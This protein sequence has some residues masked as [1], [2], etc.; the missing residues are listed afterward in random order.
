MSPPPFRFLATAGLGLALSLAV[1]GACATPP[2]T[3][4]PAAA[5]VRP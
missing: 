5:P 4:A 2:A 3:V 1:V